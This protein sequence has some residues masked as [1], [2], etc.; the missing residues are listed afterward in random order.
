MFSRSKRLFGKKK[1]W[2]WKEGLVIV[3]AAQAAS[4][5]LLEATR[6]VRG[7]F[8]GKAT[9]PPRQSVRDFYDDQRLPGFAPPP[10]LFGPAWTVN[11]ILAVAG[12]IH[13]VNLPRRRKGRSAYIRLQTASW[14]DFAI[15]S[16]ASFGLRSNL[17]GAVLTNLYL[18][19]TL[20]SL[21]EAR[22]MRE[23]IAALTL[24]TLT[25]WLCLASALSVSIFLRNGDELYGIPAPKVKRRFRVVE[26]AS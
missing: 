16:A 10:W 9:N 19:M 20:A 3:G 11:N 26:N 5:L 6:E 25:A 14:V 2:G 15:Y 8:S 12:L 22:R 17:N 13:V 4:W 7:R 23:P 1:R 18:G 24:S 21:N